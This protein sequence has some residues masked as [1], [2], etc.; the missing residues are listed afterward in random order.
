[1]RLKYQ[2]KR[3]KTDKTPC[4]PLW[5]VGSVSSVMENRPET[6]TRPGCA[7]A[8]RGAHS[9]RNSASSLTREGGSLYKGSKRRALV[10]D[11]SY[12]KPMS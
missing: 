5:L 2:K 4:V 6:G 9:P 10:V 7:Q 3:D 1:M 11:G 8:D 12:L